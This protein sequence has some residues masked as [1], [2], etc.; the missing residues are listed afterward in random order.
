MIAGQAKVELNGLTYSQPLELQIKHNKYPTQKE[1]PF[2]LYF[3]QKIKIDFSNHSNIILSKS[4]TLNLYNI[5]LDI[6]C[7]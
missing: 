6:T 5:K 4:I 2:I 7:G 3:A 1:I